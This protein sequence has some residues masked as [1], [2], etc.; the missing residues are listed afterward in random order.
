MNNFRWCYGDFGRFRLYHSA[1]KPKSEIRVIQSASMTVLFF[2]TDPADRSAAQREI[3]ASTGDY[4]AIVLGIANEPPYMR[5]FDSL[6]TF[7]RRWSDFGCRPLHVTFD[8]TRQYRLGAALYTACLDAFDVASGSRLRDPSLTVRAVLRVNA[9]F[10]SPI[11][12]F[13]EVFWQIRPTAVMMTAKPSF[14]NAFF[15][16]LAEAYSVPVRGL[17]S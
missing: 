2:V 14:P 11:H 12:L 8:R 13:A 16:A 3:A 6:G 17:A 1:A 4:P 9:D 7:E 15:R 10:I 5:E